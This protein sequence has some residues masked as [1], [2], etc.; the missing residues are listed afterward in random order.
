MAP[1]SKSTLRKALIDLSPIYESD[2][3][4]EIEEMTKVIDASNTIKTFGGQKEVQLRLISQ[5]Q[6]YQCFR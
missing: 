4:K 5:Y 3:T 6:V 1:L 2:M